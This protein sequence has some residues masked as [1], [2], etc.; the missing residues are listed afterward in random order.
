[1]AEVN[2][3]CFGIFTRRERWGLSWRGW[4]VL[5]LVLLS[6]GILWARTVHPFLAETRRVDSNVLVV[7]G[8]VHEYAI[9]AAAAEFT[10]GDYKSVFT[11]GGPVEGSRY[12]DDFKTYASVGAEQLQKIGIP[13]IAVP[14]KEV[15]RDRT[16]AS[17]VALRDWFRQNKI[18]VR[19]FNVLTE[20][21]HARRTRLLFQKA[22]GRS[23][24]VGV[25]SVPD[26]D[27]DPR[28]WWQYSAGVREI[29]S[30]SIAWIYAKFIFYPASV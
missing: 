6:A 23:A 12:D 16:Y 24:D 18:A 1:M 30:E 7:E 10:K 22:F 25:I 2:K 29:L 5:I 13:A 20:D 9:R 28:Y 17:A 15:G 4:A 19:S 8:W 26:P 21:A 14:A 27:Y 3:K 11:T